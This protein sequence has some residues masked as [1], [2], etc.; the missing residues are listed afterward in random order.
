MY[1]TL[2]SFDPRMMMI[3]S[4]CKAP[5]VNYY[6]WLMSS[7]RVD[8][9]GWSR[10]WTQIVVPLQPG[11]NHGCHD[12]EASKQR[13]DCVEHGASHGWHLC[14]T[15]NTSLVAHTGYHVS[16]HAQNLQIWRWWFHTGSSLY[17]HLI[18]VSGQSNHHCE[19]W[20]SYYL[21]AVHYVWVWPTAVRL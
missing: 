3:H 13:P 17:F 21:R 14:T 1:Y 12:N 7:N 18:L 20:T 10:T 5:N 4:S 2:A 9:A 8:T 19:N 11:G 6:K 15:P 16:T